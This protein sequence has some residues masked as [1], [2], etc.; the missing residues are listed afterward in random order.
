MSERPSSTAIQLAS[1]KQI[2]GGSF[3]YNII[4][5]IGH[6]GSGVVYR[7]H[8]EVRQEDVAVK[9]FVP[10]YA[11]KFLSSMSDTAQQQAIKDL[12]EHYRKELILIRHQALK[13]SPMES[14]QRLNDFFVI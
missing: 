13:Y 8:C 5:Y 11:Q 3:N 7:A 4:K 1:G 12:Q 2:N 6:G 9:F 14:C 10:I